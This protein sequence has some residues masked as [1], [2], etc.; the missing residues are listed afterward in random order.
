MQYRDITLKGG[1]KVNIC[2]CGYT[3]ED[4]FEIS[5]SEQEVAQ[6]TDMLLANPLMKPAGLG[7]RDSL[8]VEA[9]LC[10]HGQ[11]MTAEI[12]PAEATLLWT[13]RKTKDNPFPEKLKFIGSEVLAKQRKEGVS[14]KRVGFIVK[15]SG[16]IR[17]G[18]DV[19]DEAGNKVGLVSS[20]TYSPILKKG[21]GMIFVPP[22]L[23][24]VGQ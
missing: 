2:R 15:N 22:A 21:V 9:G 17:Q 18:C 7:A 6:L 16:I 11:D 23:S 5:V 4:G 20:G 8:R 13:V 14:K 1:M 3:G 24:A 10:L 19:L 12:S